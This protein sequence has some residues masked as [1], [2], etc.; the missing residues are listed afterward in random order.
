[1]STVAASSLGTRLRAE[2]ECR[3]LTLEQVSA[4]TKIPVALLEALERDDLSR[5]PKGFYRRA[6]LRAY[7]TTLGLQPEPLAGEFAPFLDERA[8]EPLPIAGAA[9]SP[10][11]LSPDEDPAPMSTG[12]A[13]S[14]VLRSFVLALVEAAI[15]LAAGSILGL[16]TSMSP[17]TASGAVALVYYPFIRAGAGRTRQSKATL[18]TGTAGAVTVARRG[19]PQR[20]RSALAIVRTQLGHLHSH[21]VRTWLPLVKRMIETAG[22]GSRRAGTRAWHAGTVMSRVLGRAARQTGRV[23]L[24]GVFWANQA[25]W[26]VVRTAAEHAQQLAARQLNHK[27]E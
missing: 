17:L 15:V 4:S 1:M 24:R 9:A 22:Q 27:S 16:A 12:P 10:R 23:C 25:F 5:W 18:R 3:G 21:V 20:L 11:A 8:S 13:G 7:V 6:L 2:R 26:R 19:A 14:G